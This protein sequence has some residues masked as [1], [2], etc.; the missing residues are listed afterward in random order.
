MKINWKVRFNNKV[1]WLAF[2]PAMLMLVK[3]VPNL[4]GFSIELVDIESNLIEVV[5]SVFLVLTI[6]GV[7]ADPTTAGVGD[8]KNALT[9]DKPNK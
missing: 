8:S 5:E 9:Y 6:V 4:F 7:V 2:I 3:A 1:F